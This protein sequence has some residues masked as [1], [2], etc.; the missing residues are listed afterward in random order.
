[1]GVE[2]IGVRHHSPACARWVRDRIR[3]RAPRFVLIEGPSSMNARLDELFLPHALPLA[4]YA[5]SMAEEGPR[6]ASFYPFAAFSPE[7]VALEEARAAGAQPLFMDLPPEDE[8]FF[9]LLNRYSDRHL[10]A[11]D[12]LHELARGLGFEDTDQLWDHLFE[13]EDPK[14]E[15]GARLQAY[16]Q[17]LR[18][19]EEASAGDQRRESFMAE[20]IAWAAQ[21][22]EVLA[23]CGGYHAPALARLWP[24]IP[25]P[26]APP[27]PPPRPGRHGSYL[28][29]FSFPRLDSFLGYASGMP[30][31]A[32][33]Q[34]IWEHGPRAGAARMFEEA[35]AGLRRKKQRVTA[36]DNIAASTLTEG[37]CRLRGHATP[38]RSDL[39]DGLA[40]SLVKEGLSAPLPWSRRGV[41]HP[42]TH[43]L[44]LELLRLFSGDRRGNLAEGTPRP[45]LV[46]NVEA[47]LSR[48]GVPPQRFAQKLEAALDQPEG[49]DRSHVLHR[50]RVLTIPGV[51][52]LGRPR[53]QRQDASFVERWEVARGLE[54][55]PAVIE[56]AGYGAT[57]EQAAANRLIERVA[58]LPALELA[59]LVHEAALAGI[60]ALP[61]GLL[62]RLEAGLRA[63]P[64]LAA[65]GAALARLVEIAQDPGLSQA[66]Q[67]GIDAV[68]AEAFSRT[69]WLFEALI[70]ADAPVVLPHVEAVVALREALRWVGPARLGADPSLVQEMATRRAKDPEAPP[71]A[72]GAATGLL[73][74]LGEA[75][76]APAL[77]AALVQALRG[78]ARPSAMADF[79]LGLFAVARLELLESPGLWSAIREAVE[80]LPE[81]A[82]LAALPSLR[83][84]FSFFPPRERGR[85]AEQIVE[86]YGAS[87]HRAVL[88]RVD[89]GLAVL[90]RQRE[91]SVLER[92]VR[93][94]L[95]EEQR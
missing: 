60:D 22:G 7:W 1:M 58:Q 65:V 84:A 21:E 18:A 54:F 2:I 49:K 17:A 48:V 74:A 38:L 35:I 88:G 37:L 63:E 70:G 44:L 90:G 57:L 8:A 13:G 40:G 81:G 15:L 78:M 50:L 64:D 51:K 93:Y 10:L 72:R 6:T 24:T 86:H 27:S 19:D 92:L 59:G 75:S 76:P 16:F 31:P 66:L 39:L 3:A 82:F 55:L 30:S 62:A 52:L 42:R 89:V 36:A 87:S 33:Q 69:A 14:G 68:T 11:S 43:P 34:A 32:Y 85:I 71:Y 61:E 80:L 83:Q 94:G 67:R 91:L 77:D 29:P 95:E 79:L 12:R 46:E 25:A 26:S 9:G 41:P 53:F 28:V 4:L 5:Y 73:A 56:A 23:I 47:E 20:M 45:L